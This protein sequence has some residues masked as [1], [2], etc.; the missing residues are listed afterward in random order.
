MDRAD[1]PLEP[2]AI[3]YGIEQVMCQARNRPCQHVQPSNIAVLILNESY[4]VR[5]NESA[6]FCLY[7]FHKRRI[8]IFL[9][10]YYIKICV[11]DLYANPQRKQVM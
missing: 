8:D 1:P 5:Y 2:A 10:V 9:P 7:L 4:A 6:C 3:T 11:F